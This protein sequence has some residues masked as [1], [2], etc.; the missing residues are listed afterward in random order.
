MRKISG[1]ALT[2]CALT[3]LATT[4]A[5]A[6]PAAGDASAVGQYIVVL[7]DGV[8]AASAAS[9][10]A[11][12]HGLSPTYLYTHALH[13]YAARMSQAA[14]QR[15]S[16]DPQV[17]SIQPDRPVSIDAQTLP[18]GIDRIDGELSSTVSGN[19]SGT[20]NVDVAVIDTGVDLDHPDLNVFTAGAKN[21][22]N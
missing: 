2:A 18:T 7:N 8:G 5:G 16:G 19:G 22:S 20:V 12:A 14:A 3:A 1:A 15:L 21:C 9:S 13:G 6:H 11:R 4:T 10:H 17:A